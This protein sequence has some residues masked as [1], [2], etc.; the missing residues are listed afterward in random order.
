M[1][2]HWPSGIARGAVDQWEPNL[3][4]RAEIADA[5]AAGT[6]SRAAFEDAYRGQVAER[7]SLLDWAARMATNTGVALLCESPEG[8]PCHC[9]LL[10]EILRERLGA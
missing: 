3:G 4:P 5:F 1:T 10:A 9:T 8:T 6:M 7:P 2:R